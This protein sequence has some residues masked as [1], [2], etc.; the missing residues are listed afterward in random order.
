MKAKRFDLRKL[1]TLAMLG[2]IIVMLQA[3]GIGMIPLP[4]FKL[5]ILHIPVILGAIL[6]GP[7]SGAFLGLVFGLCSVWANTTSPNPLTSMFFSPFMTMT[8]AIGAAKAVWVSIGCRMLFGVLTG[9]LWKLLQKLGAKDYIG[10]PITAAVSTVLHTALV[11]GSICVLFPN[12][13]AQVNET[14]VDALFVIVGTTI[15]TNGI[16]EAIVAA[17][18]TTIV[19]KALLHFMERTKRRQ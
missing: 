13:Y 5:T 17:V 2:G 12:E 6:L 14:T 10:L 16:I 19:G 4:T 11:L 18:L 3:T 15:A 9:L 7:G 1:V 8:G